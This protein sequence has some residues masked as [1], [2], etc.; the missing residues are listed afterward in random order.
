G[1]WE[2]FYRV[3]LPQLR[4]A[5]FGGMLLATLDVLAEFGA[6]G[7]LRYRTFTTEIYAE[8]RVRFNGPGASLL[9]GVLLLLCLVCLA[10]DLKVRGAAQFG[11]IGRG[12]LRRSVI[13]E[14]G[15][16]RFAVLAGFASLLMV[17]VGV[18]LGTIAYW[19]T[20]EGVA[21]ITPAQVSPQLL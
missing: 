11:R 10:A 14:L 13:Y 4:P 21:A 20:Q 8:Y 17:T 12:T 16:I 6:F 1:P 5:L 15:R 19:L 2:R 7:L 18:P 3:V 9:A